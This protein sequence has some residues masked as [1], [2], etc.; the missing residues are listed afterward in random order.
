MHIALTEEQRQV[1]EDHHGEPM[2]VLNPHTKE[3]F[4]LVPAKVYERLESLLQEEF[5][6][7]V[8]YPLVD[9]IMAED[10]AHDP[11]L[12]TYQHYRREDRS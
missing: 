11:H 4:V 3:V 7:R 10:D 1:L 9:R 5:D 6:P 12:A 2:R 8:A